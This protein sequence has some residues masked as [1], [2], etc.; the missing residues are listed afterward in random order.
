MTKKILLFIALFF[1][2]SIVAI[3]HAEAYGTIYQSGLQGDYI[4]D[5][6]GCGGYNARCVFN[7]QM[8]AGASDIN[9]IWVQVAKYPGL[10]ISNISNAVVKIYTGDSTPGDHTGSLL[11][12][13]TY[14][15]TDPTT[16]FGIFSLN[17]TISFTNSGWYDIE[18]SSLSGNVM[19]YSLYTSTVWGS[20]PTNHHLWGST[21]GDLSSN[22]AP[23]FYLVQGAPAY[24]P[25][26]VSFVFPVDGTTYAQDF[27]HW[28]LAIDTGTDGFS[29]YW[30]VSYGLSTSTMD[31]N[32]DTSFLPL[33]LSGGATSTRYLT[34]HVPSQGRTLYAQAYIKNTSNTVLATSS[35]ISFLANAYTAPT[36]YTGTPVG[37][38]APTSTST[39]LNITCD[40]TSG[41]FQSSLCNLAVYLFKPS[42]DI[43]N[44][45]ANLWITISAKPPL[46]YFMQSKN[47]VDS[48]NT[49]TSSAF[50]FEDV[51]ALN[52]TVFTPLKNGV[53]LLLW[54]SFGMFIFNR[55]RHIQI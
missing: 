7:Y 53:A 29:G 13:G 27:T 51:S 45:F 19:D 5:N 31:F 1:T 10:D 50:T 39:D 34:K 20:I 21:S 42:D 38:V 30:G 14:T 46:G 52:T 32:D 6:S 17:N 47:A 22:R 11:A 43:F 16:S 9:E 8:K 28:Q 23:V 37:G 4:F 40:D 15:S 18:I 55:F 33:S 25:P 12:T 35:L 2:S 44:N 49:S 41:L 3:S 54:F 48:I 36:R 24:T 26:T